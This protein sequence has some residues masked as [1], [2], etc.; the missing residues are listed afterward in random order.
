M[1]HRV[2][3]LPPAMS[4]FKNKKPALAYAGSNPSYEAK[5]C[6]AADTLRKNMDAA[7]YNDVALGLIPTKGNADFA[8]VPHFIDHLAPHR[9]GRFRRVRASC[10]HASQ[11]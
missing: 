9:L 4:G 6:L 1:G 7:E 2:P 3:A 5:V 8:W 11:A 10:V